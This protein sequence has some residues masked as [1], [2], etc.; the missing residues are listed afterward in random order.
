VLDQA[1][2]QPGAW[3]TLR[4]GTTSAEP[5]EPEMVMRWRACFP[6]APLL[7]LYGATECSS[8]ATVYDT[9]QL[10][11]GARRVPIG[12]PLTNVRVHV[13]DEQLR[14]VPTGVAGEMCVSGA[15]L[16]SGYLELPE[17][18]AERFIENPFQDD[19]G[20]VL[21]RTG[22]LA[23]RLPDGNLELLGRRDL[24]VK[25][26]G[27]RVDIGDV[28]AALIGHEEVAE[29]GVALRGRA[30]SQEL[31]AYVVASG[32]PTAPSLRRHLRERLPSY[33]VPAEFAFVEA[34]PRTPN[35]KLDRRALPSA[36]TV[37]RER[38]D[39]FV[40][41]RSDLEVRVARIFETTLEVEPVGTTDD[42]FELGGHSL[43]AV[44]VVDRVEASFGRR[45]PLP[46]LFQEPTVA[47]VARALMQ[48]GA[49]DIQSAL[50][51]LREGSGTPLFC[52]SGI[53]LYRGLAQHLPGEQPVYGVYLEDELT[54]VQ[55][56]SGPAPERFPEIPELAR[57]YVEKLREAWPDGPYAL[58]GVSFGG[59][60]AYEIAQ[61]LR[62]AGGEVA[63]LALL[64]SSWPDAVRRSK[65]AFVKNALRKIADEGA[66]EAIQH[67]ARKLLGGDRSHVTLRAGAIDLQEQRALAFRRVVRSY[68]AQPYDGR[69]ALFRAL[70]R[71]MP[72][73]YEMEPL[74]G[75]ESLLTGTLDLHDVPGSHLGILEEPNVEKLAALLGEL[76]GEV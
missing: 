44:R 12:R 25:V 55:T 53:A 18:S 51:P 28:E 35:G 45:I 64:D 33:M 75:W 24:Q 6:D 58:A 9:S 16:G 48:E 50:V 20:R 76:L 62:A 46:T 56:G 63:L 27:F 70:Q 30:G 3:R 26:R 66:A 60:L 42:F 14:P 38:D 73:G 69:V 71:E 22:D 43:L 67:A 41:P 68:A 40:A 13:L 72:V 74:L 36:S 8:N 21:Y 34:L 17:L 39:R 7:N 4:L 54:A 47:G 32:S 1:E 19:P 29:C 31:V 11:P 23:R 61:Q 2:R 15:C 49:P 57:G 52:I 10:A 65:T 5:I 59:F 37:T